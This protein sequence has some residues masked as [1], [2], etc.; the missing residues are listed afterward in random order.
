MEGEFADV[1]AVDGDLSVGNVVEPGEEVDDGG[2][3]ATGGAQDGSYLAGLGV[4]VDFSQGGRAIFVGEPDLLELDVSVRA[5]HF[6]S[7]GTLRHR[8]PGIQHRKQALARGHGAGVGVDDLSR[9]ADREGQLVQVKEEL[10]KVA[11]RQVAVHHLPAAVPQNDAEGEGE[12][13][14]HPGAVGAL[15][16]LGVKV[17]DTEFLGFAVVLAPFEVF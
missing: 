5:A 14:G 15:H 3:P 11:G 13:E 17:F 1:L 6:D 2:F 10:G 9:R 4:Q 16:A 8:R 7:I 12:V